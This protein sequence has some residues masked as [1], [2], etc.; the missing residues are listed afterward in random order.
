MQVLNSS[1]NLID[2]CIEFQGKT[3]YAS[4]MY[5]DVDKPK[6]NML[7]NYLVENANSREAPWF[8]TGDFNNLL[9]NEEKVGAPPRDEGSFS[10]L[11]TFYAEG[12]LHDLHH[13]GDPL[14]WR[15]TR[16]DHLVRCRLDRAPANSTWAEMFPTARSHYLAYEASDHKPLLSSFEYVRHKRRGLFCY[17][18]RLK[19]NEEVK[20]LV[21]KVWKEATNKLVRERIILMRQAIS[22]WNKNQHRNSRIIIEEK[23][24]ALETALT[25]S[26]NDRTLIG[27]ISTELKEA[28][29]AEE[30][31]WKQRSRLMW[32]RLGD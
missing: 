23:K 28:Y 15:G 4:F 8:I 2:T 27:K 19:D 22:E 1:P 11:R 25:S 6:R 13:S 16:G 10:D 14:S 17:D 29:A 21:S 20:S 31:Y 18:H 9:Y 24:A 3:F 7:W 30:N 32:L 5:G 12:D 26:D